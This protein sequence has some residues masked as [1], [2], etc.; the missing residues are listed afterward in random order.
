MSTPDVFE[1]SYQSL[2][3]ECRLRLLEICHEIL[4]SMP[5]SSAK[6]DEKKKKK[7][8]VHVNKGD[9]KRM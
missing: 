7:E 3:I 5:E 4:L 1:E 9:S 2:D 8:E 6:V